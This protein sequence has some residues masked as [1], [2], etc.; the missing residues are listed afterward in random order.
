MNTQP[1]RVIA[2]GSHRIDCAID[3]VLEHFESSSSME[4]NILIM[5]SWNVARALHKTSGRRFNSKS[6]N[7]H[8]K[9]AFSWLRSVRG[10]S[11]MLSEVC[12]CEPFSFLSKG[13]F[14]VNTRLGKAHLSNTSFNFRKHTT[15]RIIFLLL[16]YH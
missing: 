5:S 15:S 4:Q 7:L 10:F 9:A 2:K 13:T 3:V 6:L 8:A 14:C 16:L 11:N 1:H 12:V